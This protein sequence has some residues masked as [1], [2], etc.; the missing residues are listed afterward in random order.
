MTDI[1]VSWYLCAFFLTC[2]ALNLAF[3]IA[4]SFLG[5]THLAKN[6]NHAPQVSRHTNLATHSIPA[7]I[8][9]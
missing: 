6:I 3:A 4:R 9:I 5:R 2:L 1:G 8:F 7:W